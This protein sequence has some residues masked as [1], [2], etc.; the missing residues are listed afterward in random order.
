[1][2][3]TKYEESHAQGRPTKLDIYYFLSRKEK[4]FKKLFNIFILHRH[5]SN[6]IDLV[7]CYYTMLVTKAKVGAQGNAAVC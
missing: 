5:F 7:T 1:M 2:N 3:I 6:F 4:V